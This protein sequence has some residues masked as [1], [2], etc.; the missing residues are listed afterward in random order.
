ME[1][2]MEGSSMVEVSENAINNMSN[3]ST[4]NNWSRLHVS[5]LIWSSS[6]LLFKTSL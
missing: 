4:F 1:S 3:T 6:G 5:T 2:E